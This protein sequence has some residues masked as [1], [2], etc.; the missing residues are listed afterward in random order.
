MILSPVVTAKSVAGTLY[1]PEAPHFVLAGRSQDALPLPVEKIR[2]QLAEGRERTAEAKAAAHRPLPEPSA[3]LAQ[4]LS[5]EQPAENP[6]GLRSGA[7]TAYGA[8]GN[9]ARFVIGPVS[10]IDL[11]V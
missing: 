1:V 9:Q 6:A 8:Q 11:I 5:Q 10:G 7:I 4:R 3:F 2:R